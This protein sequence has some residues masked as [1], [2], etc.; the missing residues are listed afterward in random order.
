MRLTGKTRYRVG[1]RKKLVLQVEYTYATL[2]PMD[3]HQYNQ[4]KWQDAKVE[5][6]NEIEK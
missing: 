3:L 6:L 5:D 4:T 1:F 2:D